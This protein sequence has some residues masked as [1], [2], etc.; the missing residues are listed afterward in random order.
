V[1]RF[2]HFYSIGE[3][4]GAFPGFILQ[5]RG[6][7]RARNKQESCGLAELHGVT[8]QE[9]VHFVLLITSICVLHYPIE[10]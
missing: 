2:T 10:A 9:S 6:L 7:S 3:V 4:W 5:R 8:A 1:K